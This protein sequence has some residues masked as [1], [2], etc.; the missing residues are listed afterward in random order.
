MGL[1]QLYCLKILGGCGSSSGIK[2]NRMTF[3]ITSSSF[4]QTARAGRYSFYFFLSTRGFRMTIF[5]ETRRPI[6]LLNEASSLPVD[7][8][9]GNANHPDSDVFPAI[10]ACAGDFQTRCI[11]VIAARWSSANAPEL[12]RS[13]GAIRR[14]T[15]QVQ[16]ICN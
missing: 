2:Y 7:R 1:I 5:P 16:L 4:D 6:C 15:C 9:F 3:L 13:S 11:I 14:R 8:F 12:P 10:L